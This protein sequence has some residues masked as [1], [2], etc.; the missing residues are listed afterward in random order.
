VGEIGIAVNTSIAVDKCLKAGVDLVTAV[1]CKWA[2]MPTLDRVCAILH[3]ALAEHAS[4]YVNLT[5]VHDHRE[6]KKSLDEYTHTWLT[7]EM[8]AV[9]LL[10][11]WTLRTAWCTPS[12]LRHLQAAK[13]RHNRTPYNCL[14]LSKDMLTYVRDLPQDTNFGWPAFARL[15]TMNPAKVSMWDTECILELAQHIVKLE[16][17]ANKA[18]TQGTTAH[19]TDKDKQKFLLRIYALKGLGG[20]YLSEHCVAA[21][22][23]LFDI[24]ADSSFLY[25]GSGSGIAKYAILRHV[26]IEDTADLRRALRNWAEENGLSI[27][28][29][30]DIT[31]RK[32][33][34]T[35]C[36]GK[37]FATFIETGITL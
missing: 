12:I 2:T 13:K 34:Y 9:L 14:Q 17:T 10:F 18:R 32:V 31:S 26:G 3:P 37:V 21:V 33:A 11:S 6:V 36:T 24:S 4:D 5:D 1:R 27:L 29:R 35:L 15:S 25:M 16:T 23:Q 19:H 28:A 30:E 7:Q 8:K 20:P 22:L